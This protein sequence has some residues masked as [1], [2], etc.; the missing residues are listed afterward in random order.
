MSVFVCMFV[1]MYTVIMLWPCI[2]LSVTSWISIKIA[3][4]ITLILGTEAS[5]HCK[6]IWVSKCLRS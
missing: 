4:W 5:L 1:C 6:R 3:E 2:C